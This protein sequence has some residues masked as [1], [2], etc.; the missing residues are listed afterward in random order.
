VSFGG[1]EL[2]QDVGDDFGLFN[3]QRGAGTAT[4]RGQ[5]GESQFTS[6]PLEPLDPTLVPLLSHVE[7]DVVDDRGQEGQKDEDVH[8]GRSETRV[9][10]AGSSPS[11][12]A[13]LVEV[14]RESRCIGNKPRWF[15]QG[16]IAVAHVVSSPLFRISQDV[17][18]DSETGESSLN[19]GH[20][21]VLVRAEVGSGHTTRIRNGSID[22]L[23]FT[24]TATPCSSFYKPC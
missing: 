13:I 2:S 10:I 8:Q 15:L 21:T 24:L 11:R 3:G 4:S 14:L 18:D 12:D 16:L 20:V 6:P 17:R 23:A 7:D 5:T 19:V 22:T 1:I 9:I